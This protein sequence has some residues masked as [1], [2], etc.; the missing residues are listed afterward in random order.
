MLGN[1]QR[2]VWA[3]AM[4][5]AMRLL[6]CNAKCDYKNSITLCITAMA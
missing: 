1:C 6:H 4:A 2:C 5:M 3:M